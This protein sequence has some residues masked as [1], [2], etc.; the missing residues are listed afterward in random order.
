[1]KVEEGKVVT[2]EYTITTQKGE[3]IESSAGRGTPLVFLAGKS[4]MLPGLDAAI[5]GM[6]ADEERDFDLPPEQAFGNTDSGPTMDIPKTKLPDEADTKVGSMFQADMPGT[7]QTVNFVIVEDR[8][9]DI[10]VRLIHPLA[11]K[12][13]HIKTKIIGLRDATPEEIAKG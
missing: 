2:L 10:Q 4:G 12:T 1:M 3:L 5:E 8:V 11:G 13:I 7:N 9:N 6:E